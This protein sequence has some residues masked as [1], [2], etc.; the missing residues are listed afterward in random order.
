METTRRRNNELTTWFDYLPIE[1][2]LMIFDYLSNNDIIYTFL[3]F[4]TRFNDLILQNQRY[5]HCLELP[6]RNFDTLENIFSV[7]GVRIES[8]DVNLF[9]SLFLLKYFPNL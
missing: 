7:I 8:L 2:I 3:F 1:V 9:D 5:L 4:N 6:K